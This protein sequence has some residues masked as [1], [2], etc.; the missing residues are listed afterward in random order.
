MMTMCIPEDRLSDLRRILTDVAVTVTEE[1]GTRDMV[2][3]G[4]IADFM[5]RSERGVVTIVRCQRVPGI[6]GVLV[7]IHTIGGFWK[8]VFG[9]HDDL[10]AKIR[11][12]LTAV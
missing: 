7:R 10:A 3:H 4:H 9:G 6:P 8:K 1:V 12:A 11:D 2:E 5:C